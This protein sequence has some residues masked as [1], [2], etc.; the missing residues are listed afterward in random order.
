MQRR[1]A[2]RACSLAAADAHPSPLLLPPTS[3]GVGTVYYLMRTDVRT[4]VSQLK[5][6][7]KTIRGW[8]EE[9][10]AKKGGAGPR[11]PPKRLPDKE[12]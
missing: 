3:V 7:A 11:E 4:G 6:N 2:A 12:G 9:E 10:S 1:G 5:R 8:L